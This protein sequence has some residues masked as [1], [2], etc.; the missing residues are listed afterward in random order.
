M[1]P[2]TARVLDV[3][4]DGEWH[5]RAELLAAA[6]PLVPPGKAYRMGEWR[7]LRSSSPGPRRR[8]D[9][10]VSVAAGAREIVGKVLC[11]LVADGR[12]ERDRPGSGARYRMVGE[13]S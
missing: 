8:G 12:I 2:W 3:L 4:A 6:M 1:S 7:R 11:G 13:R 10:D 5:T 9:D